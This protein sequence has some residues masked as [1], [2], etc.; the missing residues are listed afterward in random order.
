ML[1]TVPAEAAFAQ[2]GRYA[3]IEA[4]PPY[5]IVQ[6]WVAR[7]EG[8]LELYVVKRLLTQLEGN[9]SAEA[10]FRREALLAQHL[11]HPALVKVVDAGTADDRPFMVT[12]FVLA[13]NLRQVIDAA[14][15]ARQPLSAEALVA[16]MTP[17]LEGLSYA[18][19]LSDAQG[20]P[21][22]IVH[23]DLAPRSLLVGFG[24]DVRIADFGVAR[25]QVDDFKTVPG[26]AVG[27]LEYM[28][29]EQVLRE[30][31]G[32][33]TDLYSLSLVCYELCSLLPVV[34][35]GPMMDVLREIVQRKPLS[36]AKMPLDLP[37]GVIS[38]IERG[39][40]KDPRDRWPNAAAFLAALK[41]GLG[42]RRPWTRDQLGT[43]VR[44]LLPHAEAEALALFERVRELTGRRAREYATDEPPLERSAVTMLTATEAEPNEPSVMTMPGQHLPAGPV[45]PSALKRNQPP[46]WLVPTLV[47]AA[48]G[49]LVGGF[50]FTWYLPDT[51]RVVPTEIE[52]RAL[53][54]TSEK[55]PTPTVVALPEAETVAPVEVHPVEPQEP[56]RKARP[57]QPRPEV[58]DAPPVEPP[59]AP[60]PPPETPV[61]KYA[62]LWGS[63]DAL[64]KT[65]RADPAAFAAL[66][67]QI[68]R[69]ASGLPGGKR[70]AILA[71]LQ[72]AE[73]SL[74]V[75]MLGKALQK[76][77][78]AD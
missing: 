34:R 24:G 48:A 63:L 11:Q 22:Q 30:N 25:A 19:S 33:A 20:R 8:K 3:L 54:A 39:L 1:N 68:E 61:S 57:K 75:R 42:A 38:A 2:L 53:P 7:E 51:E 58:A 65:D 13:V 40:A 52:V 60:P 72:A 56:A 76:L 41:D 4:L 35:P 32:P 26:T 69:A 18:H 64:R 6:P 67:G 74:D 78:K 49:V 45:S 71:D 5:G 50:W 16:I 17:I 44:S 37:P 23:R 66:Q 27:T 77:E 36:L 10:R 21:L 15:V 28:A 70:Q 73:L 12:E 43:F 62:A 59:P 47:G 29:P 31:V 46:S 9:R 14:V 55:E